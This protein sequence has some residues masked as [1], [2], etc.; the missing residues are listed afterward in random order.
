MGTELEYHGVCHKDNQSEC[1]LG[2][3]IEGYIGDLGI[4]QRGMQEQ[5]RAGELEYHGNS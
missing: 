5:R 1:C 3:Y 4:A 2:G